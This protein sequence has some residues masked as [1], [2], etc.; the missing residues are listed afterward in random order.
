MYIYIWDIFILKNEKP[1][2]YFIIKKNP[3]KNVNN[4]RYGWCPQIKL[5]VITAVNNVLYC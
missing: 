3:H 1:I 2:T 5:V 4:L